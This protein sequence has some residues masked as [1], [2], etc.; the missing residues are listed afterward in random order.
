MGHLF[1]IYFLQKD[2]DHD[3]CSCEGLQGIRDWL[4]NLICSLCFTGPEVNLLIS[5]YT[6]EKIQSWPD[7]NY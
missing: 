5:T 2:L 7:C 3:L 4:V 6:S 1:G